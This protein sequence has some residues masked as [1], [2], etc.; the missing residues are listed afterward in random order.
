MNQNQTIDNAEMEIDLIEL[1]HVLL[2]KWWMIML[3]ALA[4]TALAA[5]I[6]RFAITP[7]YQS[8]TMLYVLTKTT[9]I[10]SV[11]DLQIGT[12]ISRD[13]EIIATSKPVLDAAIEDIARNE[14]I[15]FSRREISSMINVTNEENTRILVITAVCDNPKHAC[16]VANAVT[17]ATAERMAEIMKSDQPTIVEAAEVSAVPVSPSMMKNVLIG[18]LAGTVLVCG[19]LVVIFL[20]NDN[21]KT[22]D[23]VEKY[24]GETTLVMIPFIKNRG[25]TMDEVKPARK[26]SDRN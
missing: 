10:T 23:D 11:A 21:I 26:K 2:R 17:E 1:F 20:M 13:F 6:T 5:G 25:R 12:V 8:Q 18:F 24:L 9:S 15:T 7:Q 3:A 22:E 16:L 19:I 4:G 14:G